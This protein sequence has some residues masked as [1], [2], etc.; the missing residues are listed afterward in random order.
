VDFPPDELFGSQK[1]KFFQIF[2]ASRIGCTTTMATQGVD[3]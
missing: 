1:S 3:G 2:F